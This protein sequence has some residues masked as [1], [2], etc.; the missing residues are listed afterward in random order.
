[1]DKDL[2]RGIIIN[3]LNKIIIA[4]KDCLIKFYDFKPK[5]DK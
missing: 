2:I 1:M 3:A 5:N 4:I